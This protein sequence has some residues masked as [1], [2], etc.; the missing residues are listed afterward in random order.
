MERNGVQELKSKIRKAKIESGTRVLKSNKMQSSAVG[1][2]RPP[3]LA[4][5][6]LRDRHPLP[7]GRQGLVLAF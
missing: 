3:Y 7:Q 5:P 1:G 4:L 6:G 2:S